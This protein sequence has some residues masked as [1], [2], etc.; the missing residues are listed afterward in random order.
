M[1]NWLFWSVKNDASLPF[2]FANPPCKQTHKPKEADRSHFTAAQ[3]QR[4]PSICF[5]VVS[6]ISCR[7]L[8]CSCRRGAAV[9][10]C[11]SE[12]IKAGCFKKGSCFHFASYTGNR[13][14]LHHVFLCTWWSFF[15]LHT[16]S[17][18]RFVR[19]SAATHNLLNSVRV[20]LAGTK[21]GSPWES[22]AGVLARSQ[23]WIIKTSISRWRSGALWKIRLVW[24][25]L[26]WLILAQF[27]WIERRQDD[28]SVPPP[29]RAPTETHYGAGQFPSSHLF[30]W[31]FQQAGG[32]VARKAGGSSG[33]TTFY[34]STEYRPA[35]LSVSAVC[36]HNG[37]SESERH[38]AVWV[39]WCSTARVLPSRWMGGGDTPNC[40]PVL[41]VLKWKKNFLYPPVFYFILFFSFCVVSP[42]A[43]SVLSCRKIKPP[44]LLSPHSLTHS[45]TVIE[46]TAEVGTRSLSQHNCSGIEAVPTQ[47]AHKLRLKKWHAGQQKGDA[48]SR[49]SATG[50][51]R[52]GCERRR[53]TCFRWPRTTNPKH[54]VQ[55]AN[56]SGLFFSFLWA[57]PETMS[58]F[59]TACWGRCWG[60]FTCRVRWLT[61][62]EI[63]FPLCED[64]GRLSAVSPADS[65]PIASQTVILISVSA[66]P[67]PPLSHPPTPPLTRQLIRQLKEPPLMLLFLFFL[68]WD[69]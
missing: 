33:V 25:R 59:T 35:S 50:P 18:R 24:N 13:S 16:H 8:H 46:W 26:G 5:S 44:V 14:D 7:L 12:Q 66:P 40:F 57:L 32:R 31:I 52:Q 60:L 58:G 6:W 21:A 11:H 41:D 34:K 53:N 62:R 56:T 10:V 3:Q 30:S 68:W 36:I 63:T 47:A 48:G 15:I 29:R 9:R 45:L 65:R 67:S 19:L 64:G 69:T 4:L 61:G 2:Y 51:G 55:Q 49:F 23:R 1:R 37:W 27:F 17:D 42:A 22:W 20:N 39:K 43:W 54:P 38:A 28:E